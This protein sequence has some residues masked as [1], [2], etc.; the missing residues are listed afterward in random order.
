LHGLIAHFPIISGHYLI[1]QTITF[2]NSIRAS[3]NLIALNR[4]TVGAILSDI[5]IDGHT[6][7]FDR[8]S[9]ARIERAFNRGDLHCIFATQTL[10]VG[11]DFRRVD[12]VVVNGF[13]FSFNDYLQRIGR[14]GRKKDS[15]VLTV[16]QNWKPID[17]Y[18]F[19]NAKEAL[20]NPTLHI[21]PVPI[22]RNNIEACKKHA[23]GAFF[24]YIVSENSLPYSLDDFRS[25]KGITT[26]FADIEKYCIK[27]LGQKGVLSKEISP[28]LKD[29]VDYIEN[30]A[31]NEMSSS[32]LMK[33]F[34]EAINEKYQLTSLRSTDR[35]V[36]IEV[37]WTL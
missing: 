15:L 25:F 4:R 37:R 8:K 31:Q 10:E 5:K 16:C 12:V 17:H 1:F 35:E 18:Y 29:F 33:R 2:V 27:A 19:S 24:D 34:M 28:A 7:D 11:V 6:T 32:T 9:R 3:N 13:P 21:E 26:R 23:R 14:G 20:K 22:T 30:L 36:V